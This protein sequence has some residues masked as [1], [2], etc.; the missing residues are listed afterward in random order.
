MPY[1]ILADTVL[2]I[3]AVI[4]LFVVGGLVLII[5][6]NLRGWVWVNNLWFR[7]AHVI[8]I[9][10]VVLQAWLGVLCPLTTL[11]VWLRSQAGEAGYSGS[12]VQYW[13]QELLYYQAPA[14]VFILA[15]TLFGLLVVL[16]WWY[17]PPRFR[18]KK[19]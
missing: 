14:W 17:C 18:R 3:H 9:A 11:E 8:A 5:A 13:L 16:T 10:I 6:G 15:Y 7:L 2:T 1:Q 4:V 12:F 19:H